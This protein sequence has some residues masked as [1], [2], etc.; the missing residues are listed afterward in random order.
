MAITSNLLSDSTKDKQIYK[1]KTSSL[2]LI[3]NGFS[4]FPVILS[5]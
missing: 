4:L 5:V 2:T 1:I 3:V